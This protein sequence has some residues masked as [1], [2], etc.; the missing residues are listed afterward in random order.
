MAEDQRQTVRKSLKVK[1]ALI[2]MDEDA[3]VVRTV[4][5]NANGV[6]VVLPHQVSAGQQGQISF[7]MYFSGE[8]HNVTAKVKVAHCFFGS[9]EFKAGLLFTKID[10][11]SMASISKFLL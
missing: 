3:L 6:G 8:S 5:I 9:G 1:A 4:D 11:S 7:D 10:P 2:M